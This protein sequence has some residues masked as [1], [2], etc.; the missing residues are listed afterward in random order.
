M[1]VLAELLRLLRWLINGYRKRKAD[2][3]I[4]DIKRN[5]SDSW[6]KRFGR[7]RDSGESSGDRNGKQDAGELPADHSDTPWSD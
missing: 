1:N 6:A 4:E 3:E 5:P 7:V 2:D